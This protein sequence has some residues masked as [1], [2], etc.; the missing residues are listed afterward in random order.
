M[1]H[2]WP[3][4]CDTVLLRLQPY[5]HPAADQAQAT[6]GTP[7]APKMPLPFA[8]R[9][10]LLFFAGALGEGVDDVFWPG[11]QGTSNKTP[12]RPT[13][14]QLLSCDE[15]GKPS[16]LRALCISGMSASLGI[17]RSSAIPRVL[18]AGWQ[19]ASA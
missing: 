16:K 3:A 4:C 17:G 12:A 2:A 6:F 7:A 19:A 8:Q 5:H 13:G 10:R 11:G 1:T 18:H 14:L 9:K 15:L